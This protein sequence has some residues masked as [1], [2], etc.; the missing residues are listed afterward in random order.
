MAGLT[1]WDPFPAEKGSHPAGGHRPRRKNDTGTITSTGSPATSG[2][3]AGTGASAVSGEGVGSGARGGDRSP[4]GCTGA[5][6]CSPHQI[7]RQVQFGTDC[8]QHRP[9]DALLHAGV[10]VLAGAAGCLQQPRACGTQLPGLPRHLPALASST[11]QVA[12]DATAS[13]II[14]VFTT[15]SAARYM[16]HGVSAGAATGAGQQA[17]SSRVPAVSGDAVRRRAARGSLAS[18]TST[19]GLGSSRGAGRLST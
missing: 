16:P 13:A 3:G 8:I 5:F 2:G 11:V 9:C 4:C 6:G 15:T 1:G 10:S 17:A 19:T 18:S 7:L 14:T 12:G